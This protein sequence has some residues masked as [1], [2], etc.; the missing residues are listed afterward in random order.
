MSTIELHLEPFSILFIAFILV[1]FIAGL[2]EK[3]TSI[4]KNRLPVTLLNVQLVNTI[5][6]IAFF[7][8]IPYF[9]IAPKIVLFLYLILSLVFMYI[10]R[11]LIVFKFGNNKKQKAILIADGREAKELKEEIN[12]NSR[13]DLTFIEVIDPSSDGKNILSSIEAIFLKE[14][15]SMIVID[16][17]HPDLVKVIP[18]LYPIAMKGVLFFDIGKIYETIFDRIPAS[19]AGKT[20]FIE[21]MSSMAPKLVYDG[22]KRLIDFCSA[23]VFGIISLIFYPFIILALKI[24][25]V[26]NDIFIYQPRIGQYNKII[27]IIKFRT[28]KIANDNGNVQVIDNRVTSVG[29]FL[30]KSR[31]DELPQLWNVLIGEVSLIGPRPE[32]PNY[33]EQYSVAIPNYAIRHSVKPGLSGWAQIYGEHSHHGVNIDMTENKLSYDLY[34]VKHRSFLIDLKI[35][36]RTIKVLITFVGR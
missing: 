35:A 25:D 26:G 29:A 4:F 13:Y 15:V 22:V 33:V 17:H 24:E 10:W 12:N 6:G 30:R 23:I 27:K 3:N 1:Y 9:S 7:Y 11:I 34:Y 8:F 36:L 31:L 2:Y 19:M 20:W 18:Q 32:L 5:V 16:T 28:M 14:K 21:H